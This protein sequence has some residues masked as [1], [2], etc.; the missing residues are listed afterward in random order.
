MDA[1]VKSH[2]SVIALGAHMVKAANILPDHPLLKVCNWNP[3]PDNGII[4]NIDDW[5]YYGVPGGQFC[6]FTDCIQETATSFSKVWG[7]SNFVMWPESNLQAQFSDVAGAMKRV[8]TPS[9]YTTISKAMLIGPVAGTLRQYHNGTGLVDGYNQS[10]Y[11]LNVWNHNAFWP[12]VQ[13]SSVDITL[14]PGE[15]L[16]IKPTSTSDDGKWSMAIFK[17]TSAIT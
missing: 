3:P 1:L 10:N 15:R 14:A 9:N 8:Y 7:G 2:H 4:D 13:D 11:F 5:P 12:S 6:S 17:Y 16:E